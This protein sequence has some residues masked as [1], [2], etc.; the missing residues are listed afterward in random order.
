MARTYNTDTEILLDAIKSATQKPFAPFG[1]EII[2]GGSVDASGPGVYFAVQFITDCTPNT[3]TVFN[4]TG[5]YS[6][7][8][9]KAGTICELDVDSLTLP[10]G[11][12]AILYKAQ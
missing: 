7:I 9:Y 1:S 5:T 10:A 11:E 2:T 4:G 6:G 3:F 12:S 8:V